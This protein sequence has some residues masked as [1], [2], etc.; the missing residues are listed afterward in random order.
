MNVVNI[1]SDPRFRPGQQCAA[2]TNTREFQPFRLDPINQC[3]WRRGIGRADERILLKPKPFAVLQYLVDNSGRLVTQEELLDAVWPDTH[4]Q[5]EV[6]KRHIFDIRDVLGDD[7]KSPTY[8]ETH[9]RRGYQFVAAVRN[10]SMAESAPAVVPQTALVGR[11]PALSELQAS[12]AKAMTGQ[13]QIVFRHR[14]AGNREDYA[15]GRISTAGARSWARFVI[16]RGQCVEGYGGKEPYYAVLE[17]LAN[18]CRGQRGESVVQILA[19]QAPTW[20]VQLPAF[21]S[22]EQREVLQREIQGATRQ[23]MLREIVDAVE[24][25]ACRESSAAGPGRSSLGGPPDG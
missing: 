1:S 25:I 10:T 15:C 7:S 11:R 24:A 6:L 12:L 2:G 16:G 20:L 8:I 18:L 5:P 22:R 4:V 3:L 19:T 23:R 21:L 14:R 9:A 17:A 13:R